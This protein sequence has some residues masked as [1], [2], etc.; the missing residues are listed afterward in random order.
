MANLTKEDWV[1]KDSDEMAR[2]EDGNPTKPV[3]EDESLA[4]QILYEKL[5]THVDKTNEHITKIS[6]IL[7]DVSVNTAKN[8]ITTA[9]ANAI[10]ANTAKTGITTSQASAITANTAKTGITTAQA[11]AI[12]NN[13]NSITGLNLGTISSVQTN[14]KGVTAQIRHAVNINARTGAATLNRTVILS[15]GTIYTSSETLTRSKT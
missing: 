5:N 7:S 3:L 13:A 10:T 12:T 15:N 9:Q 2:M 1:T 4:V 8:G 11:S 14:V 6:N